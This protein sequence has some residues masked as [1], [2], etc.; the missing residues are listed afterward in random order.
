M[1]DTNPEIII[2]TIDLDD[3]MINDRIKYNTNNHWKDGYPPDDYRKVMRQD[4]TK[5]WIKFKDD[6]LM[7]INIDIKKYNW[8]LEANEIGQYTGKF[9]NAF[10]DDLDIMLKNI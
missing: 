6:F 8:L 4:N 3:V 5:H 1:N 2:E 7:S 10:N 9:P